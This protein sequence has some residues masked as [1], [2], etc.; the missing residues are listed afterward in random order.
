MRLREGFGA[1]AHASGGLLRTG[2]RRGHQCGPDT[3]RGRLEQRPTIS[4]DHG[5]VSGISFHS[6]LLAFRPCEVVASSRRPGAP[7]KPPKLPATTQ[8]MA[9]LTVRRK[10]PE[11]VAP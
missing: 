4:V 5:S 6:T 3:G 11:A 2:K 9:S 10:T 8:R 7:P 1:H